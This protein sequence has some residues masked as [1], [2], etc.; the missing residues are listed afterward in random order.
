MI[1]VGAWSKNQCLTKYTAGE[2]NM[3]L[4]ILPTAKPWDRILLQ[5]LLN[6]GFIACNAGVGRNA[7]SAVARAYLQIGTVCPSKQFPASS[8]LDGR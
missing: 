3:N 8:L 2:L 7:P 6:F 5:A 4:C 1:A